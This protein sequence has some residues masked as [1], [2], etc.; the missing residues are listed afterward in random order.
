MCLRLIL[1]LILTLTTSL[2]SAQKRRPV[3]GSQDKRAKEMPSGT[4]VLRLQAISLLETLASEAGKIEDASDRVRLLLEVADAFWV[5]DEERARSLF[6]LSF[7]EID[8]VSV[9][10]AP[11]SKQVVSAKQSLQRRVLASVARRDP[12]LA[13]ALIRDNSNT[14]QGAE[15]RG[16]DVYGT[17]SPQSDA[18]MTLAMGMLESDPKQAVALAALAIRGGGITQNLRLFL[19]NL[20]EKDQDAANLLFEA[21]LGEASAKSPGRLFDVLALWD[22]VYQPSVFTLGGISWARGRN[23]RRYDTPVS[24]KQRVLAFMVA[25]LADNIRQLT[26]SNANSVGGHSQTALLYSVMQQVMPS[27]T[28][29]LPD[30][31]SSLYVSLSKLEQDLRAT[32]ETVPTLPTSETDGAAPANSID[33]LLERASASSK[34]E[35][36]DGLYLLVAYKLLQLKQ[37]DRAAEVAEKISDAKRREMITEPIRF[38]LAGELIEKESYNEALEN[39]NKIQEVALRITLLARVGQKLFA[40]GDY[41]SATESLNR[42]LLLVSKAEPSVELSSATL[43]VASSF[44][45]YD[46][47]RSFETL[48]TAI[49]LT[50]KLQRDDDLW[51]LFHPLGNAT[52]LAVYN[53]NWK[54]AG[55][56]GLDWIKPLYPRAGGLTETLS[57]ASLY[58]FDRAMSLAKEIRLKALSLAVQVTI[59]RGAIEKARSKS[60]EK[61]VATS[62]I[63]S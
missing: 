61:T 52:P 17:G 36:R 26:T 50:N 1:C 58:D 16:P 27:I 44:A 47:S 18:M 11:N 2:A 41:S 20:R 55:D 21:A 35:A 62:T 24:I 14:N 8:K 3:E 4:D 60:Q 29:D 15:Q 23:A 51:A 32:G 57:Q 31:A 56:G 37:Y 46:S 33:A 30:A 19:L 5:V 38:N 9:E 22:Y 42:A 28:S 25:A 40:K 39:I 6:K 59:C 13:A 54:N 10:G 7:Q 43:S 63:G 12:S 34:A 53:Y 45:D 48:L 49:R